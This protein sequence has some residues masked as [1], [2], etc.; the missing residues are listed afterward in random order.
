[1]VELGISI[2]LAN[3]IEGVLLIQLGNE[4]MSERRK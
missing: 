3:G 2:R 1:V 4:K